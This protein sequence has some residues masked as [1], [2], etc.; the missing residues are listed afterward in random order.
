MALIMIQNAPY[1]IAISSDI[2]D[3]KISGASYKGAKV[4]LTDTKIWKIVKSDLTLGDYT[5]P[6]ANIGIIDGA[7]SL[8]V[9]E[10]GSIVTRIASATNALEINP[11]GSLNTQTDL[12][13]A[14][15]GSNITI[16]DTTKNF[17]TNVLQNLIAVVSINNVDYFR[18]ISA[19]SANTITIGAL[20]GAAASAVVGEAE[21]GQVTTV[22][23]IDGAD[24]NDYEIQFVNGSGNNVPLAAALADHLIT[25]T[26]ATDGE[27]VPDNSQNTATNIAA[28]IDLLDDFTSTM[29]GSGGVMTAMAEPVSFTGGVDVVEVSVGDKYK[30]RQGYVGT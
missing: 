22:Y 4:Y 9:N 17:E 12:Y 2:V 20:P 25:V 19:N 7:N 21:A 14:T 27:G 30:I 3:D 5:E 26:L 6:S 11:D 24:G 29:T 16:V 18:T 1:Y 15:G 13:T 23:D 28:A 8:Q 10:D